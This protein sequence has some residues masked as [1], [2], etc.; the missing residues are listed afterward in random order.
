[1]RIS[2]G[3]WEEGGSLAQHNLRGALAEHAEA[4]FRLP[5]DR[6]HGLAHRVEGVHLEE[7]LLR[8]LT[9]NC[10]VVLLQVYDKAQ[11]PALCLVAYL[12]G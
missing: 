2:K 10:L 7:L 4:P 5:D 8:Y 1:M 11:Q 3:K 6:A 12:P 9:A